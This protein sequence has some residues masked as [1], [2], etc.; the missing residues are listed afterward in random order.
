MFSLPI[1][2]ALAFMAVVTSFISGIFGMAGGMLLIGF[3][4]MVLPVAGR[5][6]VPR[7]HPDRG[8]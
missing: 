6:G 7:R 4:L 3:L 5:H 2:A 1:L 8:Q